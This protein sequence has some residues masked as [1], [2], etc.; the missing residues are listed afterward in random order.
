MFLIKEMYELW[1]GD[2]SLTKA[3]NES[4]QMLEH[5][6]EMFH[7]S[8]MS[9]RESDSGDFNIDI[10]AKDEVVNNYI[11]EARRRILKHLAITGGMNIIPGLILTSIVIDIERIGDYTKNITDLARAHPKK[12]SCGK[13]DDDFKKIEN[14]SLDVFQK[15]IPIFKTSDKKAA[16]R[17]IDDNYWIIKRCNEIVERLIKDKHPCSPQAAVTGALYTRYLKRVTAHLFNIASSVANPFEQIGFKTEEEE[18]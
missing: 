2:N 5:T 15:L 13:Y 1:R 9:L 8:I 14:T 10:Y 3:L 18:L 7:E 12:L 4:H 17:L 16:I 11:L 6:R